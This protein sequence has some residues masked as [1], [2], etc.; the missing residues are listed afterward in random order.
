MDRIRSPIKWA[1]GK[2]QLLSQF[3]LMLPKNF[4]LYIEPFVGGGAMFFHILPERSILIDNNSELINFYETVR[5]SVS[6][7][8]DDLKVHKNDEEYYYIMRSLDPKNMDPVKRASRFLYLNKTAYNGLWRVNKSGQ[9]NVP[10]GRYRSL[11][12]FDEENLIAVSDL[13]KRSK[14]FFG[15]F[16][17]VLDHATRGTFVYF[18]PPY[19][20]LSKTANFTSYSGKFDE[21]DQ[22]RLHEC[23]KRLDEIGCYIMMSNSDTEFIKELYKDYDIKIVKARRAINSRTDGRG[24]INELVVRNFDQ[25]F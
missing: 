8:I 20:P 10:F 2:G 14:I 23:F 6:D 25:S 9:F 11:K 5:D 1:G 7:L 21:M 16:E 12:I 22:I 18:D 4:D 15:D 13:L 19:H 24:M 3:D 17:M